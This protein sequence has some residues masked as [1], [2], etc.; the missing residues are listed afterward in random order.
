MG[1]QPAAGQPPIPAQVAAWSGDALGAL[2]GVCPA[3]RLF[4][5]GHA[6]T[7]QSEPATVDGDRCYTAAHPPQP[8]MA[9]T[10]AVLLDSG[11]FSDPPVKR[12]S[13]AGALDR[14][15]AWEAHA[16]AMW[17]RPGWQADALVSYDLLIDETW[18][19]GKRT[20][21][22]WSVADAEPA[23]DV[24]VAA[25]R[26][27]ASQ[28]AALSP[29][30]LLLS[31]QGVTPAQYEGCARRVLEVATPADWIGLGGWCILGRYTTW[32][33]A[34]YETLTRCLP[35]IASAGVRHV[36]ILGVLY[37][38]ALGPLLWLADQVGLT[39]S[40]DSSAPLL[41][42]ARGNAKK[43][44]VRAPYWRDNIAVWRHMLA[45]LRDTPYYA[46]PVWQQGWGL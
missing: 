16:A 31:C 6:A 12:L 15:L 7:V 1:T 38:P 39:V 10:G 9:P 23:M 17:G 4:V 43:A 41:S 5:G 35:L 37:L 19:H 46:P 22:R 20:K 2:V 21:R 27:L 32:L 42:C 30:T 25:A 3:V 18:Q 11:A 36:H 13:Y 26:Y 8:S 34:F 45:T 29:R 44:G 33:P 14:Q 24:T 28:R 40:T